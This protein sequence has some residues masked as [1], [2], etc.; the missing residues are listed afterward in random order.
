MKYYVLEIAEG[1]AKIKGVSVGTFADETKTDAQNKFDAI[2]SANQRLATAK[3]DLYKSDLVIVIDENGGFVDDRK[4][5]NPYW[6]EPS[7]EE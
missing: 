4:L 6:V 3:S 7:V 2:E 1:D 5:N